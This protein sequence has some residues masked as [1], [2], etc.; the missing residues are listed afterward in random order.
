MIWVDHLSPFLTHYRKFMLR[1]QG[2]NWPLFC[3]IFVFSRTVHTGM[4]ALRTED[5][6]KEMQDK[7]RIHRNIIY[8]CMSPISESNSSLIKK[9]RE[10]FKPG[11]QYL[12]SLQC[13][14]HYTSKRFFMLAMLCMNYLWNF[15]FA[16]ANLNL[17]LLSQFP[18][19]CLWNF[20]I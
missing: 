14:W 18:M 8:I 10:I 11:T 3:F 9:R 20:E 12:V 19:E 7:P 16:A 15:E 4:A 5:L 2:L 17:I 13:P 6:P 1:K